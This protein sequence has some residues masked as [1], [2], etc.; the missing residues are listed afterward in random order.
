[1]HILVAFG[2]R[3]EIIKLDPVCQALRRRG[4][5]EL[6]VFWTGQHIELAA[7]LLQLFDIDVTYNGGDVMSEPS[8]ASKFGRMAR[9]IDAKL[10]ARRYDW[11][12]VQGDTAQ[13]RRR[14]LPAFSTMYPSPMW[15]RVCARVTCILHGRR[16]SIA[17]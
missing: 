17:A 13:R 15:K 3:P 14:L 5:V 8:L 2:T 11:I 12:V 16:N 10:Q 7:G 6:S 9:E 1:M 4:D